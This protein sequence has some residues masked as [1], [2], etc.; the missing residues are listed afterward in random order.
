MSHCHF[1]CGFA[2]ISCSVV[3]NNGFEP[4]AHFTDERNQGSCMETDCPAIAAFLPPDLFLV[5]CSSGKREKKKFFKK[6][7]DFYL[8]V[9]K[10]EF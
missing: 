9:W 4:L 8:K 3:N 1:N 2:K 6:D 10:T 7:V 5:T